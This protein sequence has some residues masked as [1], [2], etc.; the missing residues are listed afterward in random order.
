MSKI[1]KQFIKTVKKVFNLKNISID[2]NV[3]KIKNW[4]SLNNVRLIISLNKIFKTK[5]NDIDFS[6]LKTLKDL[7][8]QYS[9]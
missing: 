3:S 9:K 5:K 1:E 4:D 6:N 8:K 7:I 2:T